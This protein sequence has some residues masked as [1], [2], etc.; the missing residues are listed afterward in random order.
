M[1]TE[2]AQQKNEVATATSLSVKTCRSW[3]DLA[4]QPILTAICDS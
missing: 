3:I 1:I 4:S 2:K